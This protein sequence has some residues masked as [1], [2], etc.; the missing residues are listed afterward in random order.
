MGD[1]NAAFYFYFLGRNNE[2]FRICSCRAFS[3]EG[4]KG[5]LGKIT[6]ALGCIFFSYGR[7]IVLFVFLA[8]YSQGI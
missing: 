2:A 5:F 3:A 1:Y 6:F 7:I 8:I 4:E